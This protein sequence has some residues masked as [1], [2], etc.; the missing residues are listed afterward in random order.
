MSRVLFNTH[1]VSGQWAVCMETCTKYGRAMA[2]SFSSLAE[3]QELVT[4]LYDTTTDPVTNMLYAD[5]KGRGLWIPFRWYT[6]R[7]PYSLHIYLHINR[8]AN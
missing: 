7:I 5:A 3:M 8:R 1:A 6:I 4:W 2:P